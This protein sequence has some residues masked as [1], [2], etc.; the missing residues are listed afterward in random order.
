MIYF[1][2]LN[3]VTQSTIKNKVHAINKFNDIH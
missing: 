1:L 2:D 3:F